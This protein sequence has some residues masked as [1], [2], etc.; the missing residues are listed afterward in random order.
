MSRPEFITPKAASMMKP[1]V[2]PAL[3]RTTLAREEPVESRAGEELDRLLRRV[4]V[5]QSLI[6]AEYVCAEQIRAHP[7]RAAAVRL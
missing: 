7:T 4:G 1:V 5:G 2:E 6:L 3:T